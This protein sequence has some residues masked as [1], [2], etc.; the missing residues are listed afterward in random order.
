[1]PVEAHQRRWSCGAD[2]TPSTTSSST[3]SA[4]RVAQ[5]GTPRTK[6]LVPSIGSMIQ[7]RWLCPVEPCSSP[8]TASRER[9]RDERAADAL[10]DGLVGV[11]DRREVGLAHHVQVE[12]LEPRLGQRVGV[13]GQHVGEAEVVGVVGSASTWPGP[14]MGMVHRL[15]PVSRSTVHAMEINGLPLHPLVVH[16]AV[17]L[18]PLAA[19]TGLAYAVV[20]RWR[21]LLR[22][23]LVALSP[24]SPPSAAIV[25]HGGAARRCSTR[26]PSSR[27]LVDD[28]ADWGELLRTA[29]IAYAAAAAARRLG[30]GRSVARSSSGRAAHGTDARRRCDRDACSSPSAAVALLVLVFL[31]GDSGARAVWG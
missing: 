21:W 20:P 19:L 6:F 18:G 4:I 1:M 31:T 16:A 8:I 14:L 22:W 23:P 7:R 30:A 25:G 27:P 28:H 3:T 5:T 10:L 26:D 15:L 9:T 11:G 13:V 2:T 17:V 24:S 12:R 29:S